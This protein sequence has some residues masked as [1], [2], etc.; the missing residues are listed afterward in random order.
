MS[1][2]RE[3]PPDEADLSPERI[4]EIIG[5]L[6]QLDNVDRDELLKAILRAAWITAVALRQ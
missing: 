3:Q 2:R 1:R 4:A 5:E 6:D